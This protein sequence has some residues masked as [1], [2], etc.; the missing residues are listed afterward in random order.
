M[1]FFEAELPIFVCLPDGLVEAVP[2]DAVARGGARDSSFE[3][4]L[5]IFVCPV[6]G[7]T[8]G[9]WVVLIGSLSF[10]F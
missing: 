9:R 8:R 3:A 2:V 5:P 4:E 7:L 10:S 6:G 1:S